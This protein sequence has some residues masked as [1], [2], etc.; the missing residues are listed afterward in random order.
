MSLGVGVIGAGTVGGGVIQTLLSNAGT[1][2]DK[3]GVEI[4][5][6]HVADLNTAL[7]EPYDLEGVTVSKDAYALIEDPRVDVVCELI[8]GSNPRNRS[9]CAPLPRKSTWS[10]QTRCSLPSTAWS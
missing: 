5:L 4:E 2:R 9:S 1:I 10:R 8:G 7:Y 6:R 3:A